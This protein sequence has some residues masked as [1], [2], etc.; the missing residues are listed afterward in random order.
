MKFDS[1]HWPYKSAMVIV[2]HP[3]DET[4]WAGGTILMH[5][6]TRWTVACLCRRSDPDR[7][8]KFKKV[9]ERLG[10]SGAMGDLDDGPDQTPLSPSVVQDAVLAL[11]G[12]ADVDLIITHSVDG[13]YTRHRRH[14]EIG[15]A[16][17][18]LC[19]AGRLHG[20]ELWAFAYRDARAIAEADLFIEVPA[21]ILERKRRLVSEVYGFVPESFEGT[22]ARREEAF[23]RL[24][25]TSGGNN[26]STAA[27]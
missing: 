4:I 22:A 27:L 16:V 5:P 8:P 24:R 3:D 15:A 9:L 21:E 19:D 14:E 13:E 18:E 23:R 7:A 20:R 1:A 6:E 25:A 11:A 12:T 26:E 10:A 17:L 2:A